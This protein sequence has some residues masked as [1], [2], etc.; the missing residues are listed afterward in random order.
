MS[1]FVTGARRRAALVV[2]RS[3]GRR[4]V[5]VHVG[6]ENTGETAFLSKYCRKRF[7][8]PS[9]Q[10]HP[11][12]YVS[13]VLSYIKKN[14]IEVFFPMHDFELLPVLKEKDKF[15]KV[16]SV[17]FPDYETVNK[18]INKMET[19]KLAEKCNVPFPKSVYIENVEEINKIDVLDFPVVIKPKSQTIFSDKA[20]ALYVTEKNYA[21]NKQELITKTSEILK[22]S[23]GVII[24]EYVEGHGEGVACLYRYGKPK[25]F[26]SYK[27]VREYPITGGP[28]TL[29]ESTKNKVLMEYARNLL[30]SLKWHGVAMVEFKVG[31][32]IALM[33]INGRFWGS[34]ALPY[35][36]GVDFPYLLYRMAKDGDVAVDPDYKEGVKC[37]WLIPGDILHFLTHF[38]KYGD[39]GYL[40]NF[41]HFRGFYY[42]DIDFDDLLP[43]VG[44]AV[45]GLRYFKDYLLRKRSLAGEYV[46]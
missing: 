45:T 29:R 17:P 24:Q 38:M 18:T 14:K 13:A 16:T 44:A 11:N 9:P 34:V 31:K 5:E 37:R 26:F 20:K 21:K 35:Y 7:I 23:G 39:L 12:E 30:D 36:S 22:L 2:V 25:V 8:Y 19:Y 46:R 3:I 40:R 27:R 1:L 41:F 28:S 32:K 4:G 10:Y 33:E 42:D 6:G 43:T 15:D